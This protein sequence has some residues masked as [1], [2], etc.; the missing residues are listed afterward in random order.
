MMDRQMNEGDTWTDIQTD[1]QTDRLKTQIHV[2]NLLV[3]CLLK[4]AIVSF[5]CV[6]ISN[7]SG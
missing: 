3:I 2:D 4:A 7:S 5:P 6:H 1:R